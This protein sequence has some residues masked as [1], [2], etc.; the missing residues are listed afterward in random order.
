MCV[1]NAK[2]NTTNKESESLISAVNSPRMWDFMEVP[3]SSWSGVVSL[4]S[5]SIRGTTLTEEGRT[6]PFSGVPPGRDGG[7]FGV[8]IFC[9]NFSVCEVETVRN[10]PSFFS[11]AYMG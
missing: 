6:G 5:S 3:S 4:E 8:T 2:S 11:T 7:Y 10:F 1:K 9:R